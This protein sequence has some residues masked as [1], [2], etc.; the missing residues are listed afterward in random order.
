MQIVQISRRTTRR[1]LY[2]LH[3]IFELPARPVSGEL[4]QTHLAY[5]SGILQAD[6]YGGHGELYRESRRPGTVRE[7]G[8][9][10]HA[11]RE[12]FELADIEGVSRRKSRGE[13]TGM[14]YPIA[15]RAVKRLD[16]LFDI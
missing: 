7:A 11:R 3:D 4:P 15:L 9:F 10:A 8:C 6:A 5:W 1:R 13:R 16:A 2:H 14:V 12:F